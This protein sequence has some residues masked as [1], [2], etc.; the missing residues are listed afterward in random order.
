[1]ILAKKISGRVEFSRWSVAFLVVTLALSGLS[2]GSDGGLINYNKDVWTQIDLGNDSTNIE[3]DSLGPDVPSDL[4]DTTGA[5]TTDADISA[6]VPNLPGPGE[7]G[8]P[9][10]ENDQCLT[11]FCIQGPDGKECAQACVTD[12]PPDMT[13]S[14]IATPLGDTAF[15]CVFR[16][17]NLCRPCSNSDVCNDFGISSSACVDYG[18]SGYF[19]GINCDSDGECPGGYICAD[20]PTIGG[21]TSSQCIPEEGECSCN[22]LAIQSGALTTCYS[23]NEDGVC[24]GTRSCTEDGLSDCSAAEPAPEICN[25]V[26]DDCDGEIDEDGAA[27]CLTWYADNDGDGYGIGLGACT[28]EPPGAGFVN[29]GGDCND[30]ATAVNPGQDEFCNG[31]DDDCDDT[32]DEIGAL[33]CV[34]GYLDSD[35]DG[36]GDPE[37]EVCTCSLVDG[38]SEFDD[39][40]DDKDA[41]ISP[42]ADEVCGDFIDNNC[43]EQVD[44]ENGL[45]CQVFY[46]DGDGD[47]YGLSANFECLCEPTALYGTEFSGDCND[48]APLIHP[49]APEQCNDIDDD[50]DSQTDEDP[51]SAMCPTPP[52]GQ[53]ACDQTCIIG[54]CDAGFYDLNGLVPD[55]CECLSDVDDTANNLCPFAQNLGSVEDVG[56][57]AA[58]GNCGESIFIT[59]QIVPA[60]DEDWYKVD[61]IDLADDTC[62]NFHF[63]VE[64]EYNPSGAYAL[65]VYRGSCAGTDQQCVLSDKYVFATDFRDDSGL[66]PYGQ[67]PCSNSYLD[68]DA[69]IA[70]FGC[71][72]DDDDFDTASCNIEHYGE[73]GKNFCGDE[74]ATFHIRVYL[75]PDYTGVP[76]CEDYE[77]SIS[78]GKFD[79]GPTGPG[80]N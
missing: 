49:F 24:E 44:E 22:N 10:T 5:D 64:L 62:D 17:L 33:G 71:G 18:P 9:C 74:S 6:D 3:P 23:D 60:T 51:P 78:N 2:C 79:S 69:V 31:I 8:Y 57:D 48:A 4:F 59:G 76:P 35:G 26:D 36:H 38:F 13:C 7:P 19:C 75:R 16:D 41:A 50:C 29:S 30:S 56:C 80:S 40:C 32:V 73:A 25:G 14:Q 43:D 47:G 20:V 37:T 39:D 61:A 58:T 68:Q 72:G 70:Q 45:G 46:L 63:R 42:D 53:P 55:G 66:D 52:Q 34:V 12:C 54:S 28:C 27:G 11:P 65:D 15:I 77:L 67:C 21:S 1:M